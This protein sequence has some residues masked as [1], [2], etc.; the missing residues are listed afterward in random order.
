M[1]N[2]LVAVHMIVKNEEQWV[3]YA[4][5]SVINYVDKLLIYDTG[6]TDKTVEIIKTIKS[7]KIMFM[8]KG[9]V[10]PEGFVK[11]RNEQVRHTKT[12]WFFLLDGDEVWPEKTVQ[13]LISVIKNS[14][15]ELLGLVFKTRIPLGDLFHF[16]TETAGKYHI[17]GKIGHYNLRIY[18]KLPGYSWVGEYPLEAYADSQGTT[19]QDQSSHLKLLS[20][21]YWHLHHLKRSSVG[22]HRKPKKELGE[23]A[24]VHL[25]EVFFKSRPPLVP[26]PWISYSQKE[27]ILVHIITPLLMAKR[28]WLK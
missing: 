3:W 26:S 1:N 19:I 25:P 10:T 11:L 5:Q 23:I 24:T 6:S 13:E 8:E 22:I 27:K 17:L 21:E 7:E 4:I 18:R 14:G 12:E 2:P 15:P 16:Q 28:Y 9:S 20:G